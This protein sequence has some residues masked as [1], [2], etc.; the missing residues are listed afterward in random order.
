MVVL[1]VLVVT[2]EYAT[3]MIRTSLVAVPRRRRLLAAKVTVLLLVGLVTSVPIGFGMFLAGQAIL[4]GSDVPHATLDQ[5]QVLRAVFGAGLFLTAAAL[6]GLAVGV[7]VRSTAGAIAFLFTTTLLVP[8][9]ILP[10]LPDQIGDPLL[11][12]WPNAAGMAILSTRPVPET[13]T[14]WTGLGWMWLATIAVLAGA[15]LVFHAKD[16]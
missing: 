1:G 6:M 15:F 3:G 14:P 13:L 10:S 9:A 2:S 16:A 5:P 8:T 4:A 7:I 12:F 11:K